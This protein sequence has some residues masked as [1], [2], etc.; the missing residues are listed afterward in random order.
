MSTSFNSSPTTSDESGSP[1]LFHNYEDE[2]LILSKEINENLSKMEEDVS[3]INASF[4][5]LVKNDMQSANQM[6]DQ[7]DLEIMAL[8][9]SPTSLSSS[10]KNQLIHL[11]EDFESYKERLTII[12]KS[13]QKTPSLRNTE[14]DSLLSLPLD[15][16]NHGRNALDRSNRLAIEAEQIGS[17]VLED[18]RRQREQIERAG[19]YLHETDNDV[20]ISNQILRDIIKKMVANRLATTVIFIILISSILLLVYHKLF[21]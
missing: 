21:H 15:T 16:S 10:D 20:D 19:R 14:M 1:N 2:Y 6:L 9:S 5:A 13:K 18:L 12:A 4:L 3:L 17:T 8:P 11:R 7:M